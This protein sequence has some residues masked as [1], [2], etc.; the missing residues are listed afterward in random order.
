MNIQHGMRHLSDSLFLIPFSKHRPAP[1]PIILNSQ[2]RPFDN[3]GDSDLQYLDRA[4]EYF[5]YISFF[6]FEKSETAGDDSYGLSEFEDEPC[7]W[8]H[9]LPPNK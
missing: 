6:I 9:W 4:D 7:V 2:L 8:L 3:G 1:R 5:D